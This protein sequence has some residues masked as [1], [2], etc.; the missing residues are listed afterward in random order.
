MAHALTAP[1]G[2]L[3]PLVLGLGYCQCQL[4]DALTS[5]HCHQDCVIPDAFKLKIEIMQLVCLLPFEEGP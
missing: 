1:G 5:T 4:A 3:G 2:G